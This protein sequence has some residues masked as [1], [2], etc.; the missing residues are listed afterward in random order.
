[1]LRQQ[2]QRGPGADGAPSPLPAAGAR[3]GDA[4]A[5]ARRWAEGKKDRAR[6]RG[7][8]EGRRPGA[9][10][11]RAAVAEGRAART[12]RPGC[13]VRTGE[14][15]L[16]IS[17]DGAGRPAA[18]RAATS[19]GAAPG[20]ATAT[21][22]TCKARATSIKSGTEDTQVAGQDTG[23]G[24]SRSEVIQGA[25][26][27]GFASRGYQ[28]VYR[29]Y[30]NVA[31]EALGKDEIPGG[32]RFYVR[33]YFQLIRPRE[34]AAENEDG[35]N[36]T[37]HG[38]SG[39]ARAG[40][41]V[42]RRASTRFAPRSRRSI[43]GNR[44]VVDGVLTCMLAGGHA[45]LEG[46]PGLGKTMLVRTLRETLSLTFSRIQFTPDLMPAD[47]LGTTMIDESARRRKTFEFRQR[48]DL[49]EHRPRRRGEPRDPQDAERAPRGDAGAPRLG[50]QA[51]ARAR[52]AVRRPRDA[53]PARDGRD[54]PAPRGAAR[55]LLLQ[56]PRAVSRAATSCTTI[57]DRTTGAAHDERDARCSTARASSRCRSSCAQV[58]VARHVQDYAVRVLQATHPD[59]PDAPDLA[60]A[61]RALRRVARAARR[62]CSSPR[63]SARSSRAASPRRSTTCA[64]ASLP[65]AA[66]PRAPQ[67]RGRGRG[68]R[69]PTRCIH[70]DPRRAVPETA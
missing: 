49:R 46:V 12:A 43:V 59:G 45:L 8:V 17:R 26:E 1:M 16:M 7:R 21:T 54:V 53:E 30:Q 29:E 37:S 14:P 35:A 67:L 18:R 55:S 63:R 38:R 69:R 50:R 19:R 24:A 33:R 5:G 70:A 48:A 60:Q 61:L 51:D 32:Y 57:L 15:I 34:Q 11:G 52:G 41:G 23:Q 39:G 65:G 13:S 64:R 31:E 4:A 56:A 40:D 28:K 42:P 36:E 6:A 58:P 9:G 22:R 3:A 44:D 2:R 27:R 68:D 62:P 20:G 47:I 10:R 66:P 25:A